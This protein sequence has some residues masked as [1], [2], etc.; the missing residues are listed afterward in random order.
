MKVPDLTIKAHFVISVYFDL[1]NKKQSESRL[2]FIEL[3]GSEQA[4]SHDSV[5]KGESVKDFVTRSFNSLSSSLVR[6]AL[7]KKSKHSQST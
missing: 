5:F 7:N 6:S 2:D 1:K 4:V 3:C